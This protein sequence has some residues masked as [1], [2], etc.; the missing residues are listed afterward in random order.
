MQDLTR[1]NML[2][3]ENAMRPLCLAS[4]AYPV[5]HNVFLN[6]SA[7]KSMYVY[8]FSGPTEEAQSSFAD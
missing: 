4:S 1:L 3:P 6:K 5:L 2:L 8:H 7:A